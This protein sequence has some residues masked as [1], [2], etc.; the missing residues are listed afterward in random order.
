MLNKN[1]MSLKESFRYL[2]ILEKHISSLT[3]ILSNKN[4][5]IKIEEIHY[6]S[7]VDDKISDEI[8]NQTI[9]RPYPNVT[10]IDLSFLI[11]QLLEQKFELSIA[12]ELAKRDL[13]LDWQENGKPLTLDSGI[14]FAKKNR[15]L[16]NSLK[17]LLD[18]KSTETKSQGNGYTFNINKDQIVYKYE[19]LKKISIDFDRNVV[20]DLYKKLISKADIISIQIDSAMLKECVLYNPLYD[21]HDSLEEIVEKYVTSKG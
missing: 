8:I 10:I 16:A 15:E 2:N 20:K 5:A 6:K 7:K 17:Y 1:V 4:N 14:E 11:K 18:I 13:Q 9:E 19:I 21:L 12:I 3:T